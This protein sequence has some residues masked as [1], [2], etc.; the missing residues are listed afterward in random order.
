M[1]HSLAHFPWTREEEGCAFFKGNT[2]R[3]VYRKMAGEEGV[4]D[5]AW[6][7]EHLCSKISYRLAGISD[8]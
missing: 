4:M 7:L 8:S 1:K 2:T 5:G 6:G 3:A